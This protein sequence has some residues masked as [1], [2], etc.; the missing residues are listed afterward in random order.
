MYNS[1]ALFPF[2]NPIELAT[3]EFYEKLYKKKTSGEDAC[4]TK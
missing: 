3:L 2:S 1:C 4:D